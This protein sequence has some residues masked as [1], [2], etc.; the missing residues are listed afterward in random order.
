MVVT[1][2][3]RGQRG[4]VKGI[5]RDT[6]AFPRVD[7][8]TAA[9][10]EASDS[11]LRAFTH[12]RKDGFFI[13]PNLPFGNY[14]LIISHPNF[15]DYVEEIALSDSSKSISKDF[16]LTSKT[17]LINEVIIQ[18]QRDI[19]I[20]GDTTEFN[21]TNYKLLENASA[22]DLLKLLPGIKVDKDGKITAYGEAVNKVYVDGEEFFGDDPTVATKNIKAEMI[23]KVQV[24]DK[25]TDQEAITGVDDGDKNTVINLKLKDEFK[26]GFFGKTYARAGLPNSLDNGVMINSFKEKRKFSA[27]ITHSNIGNN[28]LGWKDSENYGTGSNY[29]M[30]DDG[31]SYSNSYTIED[32]DILSGDAGIS[33][34]LNGGV[35][36][37]NKFLKDYNLNLNSSYG[38]SSGNRDIMSTTNTEQTVNDSTYYKNEK[39]IYQASLLSH[40]PA[41]SLVYDLDSSNKI[42][43]SINASIKNI[44]L[45]GNYISETL[46][47]NRDPLNQSLRSIDQ[48]E[49]SA[50]YI[51][52]L[53][54]SHKFK[55]KGRTF[56]LGVNLDLVDNNKLKYI[57]TQ[58][59]YYEDGLV[60][61][62][63]SLNQKNDNSLTNQVF[64][65]KAA[66]TESLGKKWLFEIHYKPTLTSNKSVIASAI[67]GLTGEYT[68]RLDT[69]SNS[70]VF[71]TH[72]HEAGFSLR[73]TIKGLNA[74]FVLNDE[75]GEQQ[76]FDLIH[77][78]NNTTYHYNALNPSIQLRYLFKNKTNL[79]I[80]YNGI[81]NQ[82][83]INQLQPIKDYS[84][85]LIIYV[86][87]PNLKPSYEHR[88]NLLVHKYNIRHSRY[89]YTNAFYNITQNAFTRQITFSNEGVTKTQTINGSNT[90][91]LSLW[92]QFGRNIFSD[93]IRVSCVYGF[94][95]SNKND[96]LNDIQNVSRTIENKGGVNLTYTK[97]KA[98]N[99]SIGYNVSYATNINIGKVKTQTN[100]EKQEIGVSGK[101]NFLKQFVVEANYSFSRN[102][103]NTTTPMTIN[104]LS[105][106][107]AYKLFKNKAELGLIGNNLFNQNSG[108]DLYQ[109]TSSLIRSQH[110]VLGRYFMVSFL[111]NFSNKGAVQKQEEDEY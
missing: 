71:N 28:S 83:Q 60:Q 40:K 63:D 21:A 70:F 68:E 58:Q 9:V 81:T 99:F 19:R 110:N 31:T 72:R 82:P 105:A 62:M 15:G 35:N 78:T 46:N 39:E 44:K 51:Q 69:L 57:G 37:N 20:N 18:R 45:K 26:K 91:R 25:K 1:F 88:L 86:G 109:N 77:S 13:I 74:S 17:I 32:D 22:E 5:V 92:S 30:Y 90:A 104:M 14:I 27:Y 95:S 61:R 50:S 7:K 52:S 23:D 93:M 65:L 106:S 101:L 42:K 97:E 103:S 98:G 73:Y 79:N 84:N 34:S 16:Y 107:A 64:S 96:I 10:I 87:N 49:N 2:S 24:Y 47:S 111:Y 85:P 94:N 38:F 6:T 59:R 48:N 41:V 36:Y 56:S 12:T 76:R 108:Y 3:V 80:R 8:A 66:F 89:F 54:L 102:Q 100:I 53:L 43:Y 11:V 67:R 29:N 4:E 33:N 55:A 75:T